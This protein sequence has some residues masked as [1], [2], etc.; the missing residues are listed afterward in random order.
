MKQEQNGLGFSWRGTLSKSEEFVNCK[1]KYHKEK[2]GFGLIQKIWRC[3][4]ATGNHRS[5]IHLEYWWAWVWRHT[6]SVKKVVGLKGIK[7][8]QKQP[9]EK[10]KWTIMLTYVNAA[11]FTL[12]LVIHKGKYSWRTHC[13][14]VVMVRGSSSRKG[15]INKS[16][17]T[18]YWFTLQE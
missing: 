18:E 4:E 13:P 1:G 16:L 14:R 15:Y 6:K 3:P 9:Y 17:F 10:P 12:L 2:F 7:Q 8:F 11:G 5:E